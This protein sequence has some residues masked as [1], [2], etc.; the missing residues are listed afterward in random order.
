MGLRRARGKHKT[1]A[2][3][4]SHVWGERGWGWVDATHMPRIGAPPLL[5]ETLLGLGIWAR[6]P[7]RVDGRRGAVRLGED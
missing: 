4:I 2:H 1:R 7:G 5:G 3:L 6:A